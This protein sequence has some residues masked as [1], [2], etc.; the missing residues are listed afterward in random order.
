[1]RR[2]RGTPELRLWAMCALDE[3][4]A[5]DEDDTDADAEADEDVLPANRFAFDNFPSMRK[6]SF[7]GNIVYCKLFSPC[8]I[9]LYIL[10][11]FA[12][13]SSIYMSIFIYICFFLV[14][15]CNC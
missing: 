4:E 10:N 7:C 6:S 2:F 1:M 12:S 11:R 8:R 13:F 14:F 3:Q 5:D 9:V 15:F